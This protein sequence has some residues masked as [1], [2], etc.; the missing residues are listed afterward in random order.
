M[1]LGPVDRQ[2]FLYPFSSFYT[3]ILCPPL[4]YESARSTGK[5][6]AFSFFVF[7][8]PVIRNATSPPPT[9]TVHHALRLSQYQL[10]LCGLHPPRQRG[11]DVH[12]VRPPPAMRLPPAH[13]PPQATATMMMTTMTTRGGVRRGRSWR[14]PPWWQWTSSWRGGHGGGGARQQPQQQWQRSDPL[15]PNDAAASGGGDN[16]NASVWMRSGGGTTDG[17]GG[18]VRRA[19][20]GVCQLRP[21][22][23]PSPLSKLAVVDIGHRHGHRLVGHRCGRLSCRH[24]PSLT[25]AIVAAV[26]EWD[27]W[28][29]AYG[30][31]GRHESNH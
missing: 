23:W 13:A 24:R 10:G 11:K 28:W 8:T 16:N 19:I 4:P 31:K 17:G 1:S 18:G 2:D 29:G 9:P 26:G 20:E 25:S 22:S 6:F 27:M 30:K 5:I 14:T 7:C 12:D 3:L 15:V 21:L